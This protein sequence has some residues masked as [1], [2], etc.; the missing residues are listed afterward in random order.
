MS[1]NHWA[2]VAAFHAKFG[3]PEATSDPGHHQLPKS[4]FDMAALIKFRLQ[5]MQEELDEF[6]KGWEEGD[7][8]QMA[9]A[10]IDLEYVVL[11][12]SHMLGFPHPELWDDVQAANMRKERA[13]TDGSNSKR[14]SALDV[15]KPEGWV[16][17]DGA[18]ILRKY[19][20]PV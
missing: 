4:S 1:E 5:F 13:A 19:G 7:Y 3:L 14:G 16:G 17:P 20:Y 12:T 6:L 2:D 9:D 15:I 11:G 18:S 10:L 8:A